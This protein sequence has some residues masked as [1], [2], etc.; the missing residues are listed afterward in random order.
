VS[1]LPAAHGRGPA[2]ANGLTPL[3]VGPRAWAWRRR[4]WAF[5]GLLG[6]ASRIAVFFVEYLVMSVL[7]GSS[8]HHR[9]CG[10]AASTCS[11]ATFGCV[12]NPFP[13]LG[14]RRWTAPCWSYM[15]AQSV[16]HTLWARLFWPPMANTSTAPPYCA[17]YRAHSCA[18]EE[19]IVGVVY[20]V[21]L[22]VEG[23]LA[24]AYSVHRLPHAL[25][26][27]PP[28]PGNAAHCLLSPC[29]ARCPRAQLQPSTLQITCASSSR[30]SSSC[31]V[32]VKGGG[33]GG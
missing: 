26:L 23:M 25:P 29:C 16:Q 19:A 8:G 33:S 10:G 11:T 2:R 22:Q 31:E 30:A 18:N 12:V 20:L 21:G 14:V 9:H 24:Q 7:L 3:L 1:R 17:V 32:Q 27:L 5:H 13:P 15:V 6:I 4:C 28:K